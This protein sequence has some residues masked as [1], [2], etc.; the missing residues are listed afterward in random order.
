MT[1]LSISPGA[2]GAVETML[3]DVMAGLSEPQKTLSGKYF[4]DE[5]GPKLFD[6]ICELDEYYVTRTKRALM[7]ENVGKLRL[8]S[9]PR[10]F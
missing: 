1:I 7:A 10:S 3:D 2:V 9:G 6:D 5:R 4:Y 8:R